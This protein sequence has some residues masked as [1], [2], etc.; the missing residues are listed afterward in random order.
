MPEPYYK[1]SSFRSWEWIGYDY[2]LDILSIPLSTEFTPAMIEVRA[3]SQVQAKQNKT[4]RTPSAVW[5]TQTTTKAMERSPRTELNTD[6][7]W[8]VFFH[9]TGSSRRIVNL[10]SPCLELCSTSAVSMCLL[11][12]IV[13]PRLDYQLKELVGKTNLLLMEL[14]RLLCLKIPLGGNL[15]SLVHGNWAHV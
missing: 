9:P 13:T 3:L 2:Q 10:G 12:L 8:S 6:L 14:S 4:N 7:Q 11:C 1:N 5:L 15:S